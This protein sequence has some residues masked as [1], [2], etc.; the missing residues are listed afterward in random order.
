[1][2]SASTSLPVI[3]V[4]VQASHLGGVDSLLSVAQMPVSLIPNERVYQ[5][6]ST[7][8]KDVQLRVSE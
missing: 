5:T 4:P 6:N 2:I 8:R 3:G 1:M 7:R